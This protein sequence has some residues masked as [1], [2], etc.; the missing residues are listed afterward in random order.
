MRIVTAHGGIQFDK[1]EVIELRDIRGQDAAAAEVSLILRSGGEL[2]GLM[3]ADDFNAL[4]P[5]MEAMWRA[6]F[7]SRGRNAIRD[8][9]HSGQGVYPDRK[10]DLAIV[11]LREGEIADEKRAD[12]T[13]WY[14][15]C[16]FAV[17]VTLVLVVALV[18]LPTKRINT[19]WQ[20]CKGAYGAVISS[21][22]S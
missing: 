18:G 4:C 2:S 21:G 13:Y 11:W 19:I 10:R 22:S 3:P 5:K 14:L 17:L 6:E 7:E 1:R 12:N 9:I 15:K 16:T 8:A 20:W